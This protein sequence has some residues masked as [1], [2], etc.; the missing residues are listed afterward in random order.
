MRY[1]SLASTVVA[2][3]AL[4]LL[5]VPPIKTTVLFCEKPAPFKTWALTMAVFGGPYLFC[6][7]AIPHVPA[8]AIKEKSMGMGVIVR[9]DK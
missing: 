7:A 6:S 8:N 3:A 4:A 1:P 9:V 5:I 2:P